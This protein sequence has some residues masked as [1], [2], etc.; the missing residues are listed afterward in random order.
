MSNY[1]RGPWVVFKPHDRR[2]ILWVNTAAMGDEQ[3]DVAN[4]LLMDCGGSGAA[5]A[6]LI[7]AAPEMLQGLEFS[8]AILKG[9]RLCETDKAVLKGLIQI[10]TK[11]TGGES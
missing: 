6:S 5:N 7:A 11:A 9:M 4:I 3:V 2:D 10:V 8:I 1:T